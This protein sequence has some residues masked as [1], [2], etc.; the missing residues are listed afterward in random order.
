MGLK[1][2]YPAIAGKNQVKIRPIMGL[3]CSKKKK[4]KIKKSG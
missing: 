2:K 1:C 3:K 4:I